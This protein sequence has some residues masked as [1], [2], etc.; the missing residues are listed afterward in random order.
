MFINA[1]V[2]A[3]EKHLKD[4]IFLQTLACKMILRLIKGA[5]RTHLFLWLWKQFWDTGSFS[6]FSGN[7]SDWCIAYHQ[8][9]MIISLNSSFESTS[10]QSLQ[11]HVSIFFFFDEKHR[12]IFHVFCLSFE[13]SKNLHVI[14][15]FCYLVFIPCTSRNWSVSL[16][17]L[18]QSLSSFLQEENEI[19]TLHFHFLWT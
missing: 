7:R 13:C 9:I 8:S 11:V 1:Y 12:F 14:L 3:Y 17:C 4:L 19:Y 18:M 6:L 5:N 16:Q 15:M 10:K 2:H